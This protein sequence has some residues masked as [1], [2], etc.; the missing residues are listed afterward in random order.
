[1]F[2]K[3]ALGKFMKYTWINEINRNHQA[4]QKKFL[5]LLFLVFFHFYGL[6]QLKETDV[7]RCK[8][9][10]V[11]HNSFDKVQNSEAALIR[12]SYKKVL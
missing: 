12:C 4:L 11:Y 3:N 7:E 2:F 6:A 9:I 8:D 10:L 5:S 1:M